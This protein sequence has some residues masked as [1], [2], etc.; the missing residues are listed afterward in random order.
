MPDV[1]LVFFEGCPSLP[2]AREALKAAGVASPVEVVQDHLPEGH[3]RKAYSSPS[4]LVD[5]S[6][7]VGLLQA[8]PACTVADWSI[9][10]QRLRALLQKA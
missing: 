7:I 5:G 10:A 8:S 2:R 1:E 6:L 3:P 4:I 9:A